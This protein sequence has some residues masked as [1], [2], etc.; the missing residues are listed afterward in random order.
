MDYKELDGASA[1]AQA[2][3]VHL[4]FTGKL[5]A[6]DHARKWC[7]WNIPSNGAAQI[8][9]AP[10]GSLYTVIYAGNGFLPGAVSGGCGNIFALC[11]GKWT[12]DCLGQIF[13]YYT[14]AAF[15]SPEV[16]Q[17]MQLGG[18]RH[19]LK[20]LQWEASGFAGKLT[21]TVL[22][23]S[24]NNPWPISAT[25]PLRADPNYDDEW[26]GGQASGQ[27]FFLKFTVKPS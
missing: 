11:D 10:G 1:I 7:P 20:Y 2:A 26:G 3:P 21:V 4:T 24:L 16:E 15:A 18:Q 19:L 22:V 6:R 13:P 27:R 17:A 23:N 12:D 9:R 25:I 5:V 14:T 8:Y